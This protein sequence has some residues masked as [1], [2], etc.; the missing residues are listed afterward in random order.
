MDDLKEYQNRLQA[1][2]DRK[3][4][5][6]EETD[7][8][9]VAALDSFL[10]EALKHVERPIEGKPE[11]KVLPLQQRQSLMKENFIQQAYQF[12]DEADTYELTKHNDAV[13]ELLIQ[14][15]TAD[16]RFEKSP[17]VKNKSSLKKGILLYGSFGVGKS[18]IMRTFSRI[19]EFYGDEPFYPEECQCF[20]MHPA[21]ELCAEAEASRND[22]LRDFYNDFGR[23]ITAMKKGKGKILNHLCIDDLAKEEKE[24]AYSYGRN[25][26][27]IVLNDRYDRRQHG[28]KTHA[29]TNYTLKEIQ[30]FYGGALASR[31][32]S[33][34]NFITLDG[35]DYRS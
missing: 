31:L 24:K 8:E 9:N 33:M 6:L 17:L 2:R 3:R 27:K 21:I 19:L 11:R 5:R 32:K 29:T 18:V 26:I 14:Y 1:I 12:L 7:A 16:E 20:F 10:G 13:I 4:E 22:N 15:F 30:G 34:F 25:P 35:K 23:R 28:T